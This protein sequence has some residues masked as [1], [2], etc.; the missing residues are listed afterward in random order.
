MMHTKRRWSVTEVKSVEELARMLTET[1]WGCCHAFSI[2]GHPDYVW[3]NDSTSPDR[4]QE[5]AVLKRNPSEGM[6]LQ[7]ESITVSWC[8]PMEMQQFIERSLAGKDDT[9]YFVGEVDAIL[10]TPKEHDH[11]QHCA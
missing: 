3:V 6:I 1:T 2:K 7:I 9:G 5:Y 10:Q 11:C 4:L 8:T